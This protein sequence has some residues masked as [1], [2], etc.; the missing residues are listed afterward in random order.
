ML[1]VVRV[2]NALMA[3]ARIR[4]VMGRRVGAFRIA[5]AGQ[6]VFVLL[7]RMA[8]GFVRII[9]IVMSWR[10]A[11]QQRIAEREIFVRW[12]LVVETQFVCPES[13]VLERDF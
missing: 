13:V 1:F 7:L 12:G 6:T 5:G 8:R 4:F 11:A 2:V 10:G 3:H 9:S